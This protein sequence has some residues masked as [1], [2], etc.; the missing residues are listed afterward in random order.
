MRVQVLPVQVDGSPKVVMND[1]PVAHL[2]T[3]LNEVFGDEVW[4]AE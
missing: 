4:K 1:E 2:A 3:V